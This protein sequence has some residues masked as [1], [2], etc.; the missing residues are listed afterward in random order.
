MY[1]P[2]PYKAIDEKFYTLKYPNT[3]IQ[4]PVYKK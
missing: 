4:K 1:R 3:S 2:Q